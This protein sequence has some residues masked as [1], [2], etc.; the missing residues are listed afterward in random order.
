MTGQWTLGNLVEPLSG[1][2]WDVD[3]THRE[4]SARVAAF[5]AHGIEPGDRVLIHFGNNLEFFAELLAIW[6]VGACAIPVDARLTPFEVEKL[7]KAA[8]A[9][10]A[11]VNDATPASS[12]NAV[13]GMV[14]RQYQ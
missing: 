7:S 1:R 12:Q 6:Q 10:F 2:H 8:E 5:L 3:T 14:V 13:A 9:R 11:V 4:I